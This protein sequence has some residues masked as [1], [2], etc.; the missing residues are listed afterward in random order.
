MFITLGLSL[1]FLMGMM[2]CVAFLTYLERKIIARFQLRLGP[3]VVGPLG[4][5]Q[6]FADA[7]KMIHKETIIPDQC[8]R[9][10]FLFS[11]ILVFFLTMAP[12]A[13]LPLGETFYLAASEFDILYVMACAGLGAYGTLMAGWSSGSNYAFLGG[14]RAASQVIAY[15]ISATLALL[16]IMMTAQSYS[17]HQVVQAQATWWFILPHAPLAVTFFIALLAESHRTPFD[18]PEAESDL[19]AGYKVEYS[20]MGF[21]L[22]MLSEYAH[23]IFASALFSLCFLGGWLPIHSALAW[24][25][26]PL[27][28][29][30]KICFILFLFIWIRST[31]PRYRYDQLMRIGWKVLLPFN[32]IWFMITAGVLRW[33]FV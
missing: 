27:W 15:E 5:L 31:F 24:I 29:A 16:C 8:H 1:L 32:L 3:E 28:M 12:W 33:M 7:F 9:P 17:F 2:V 13:V 10:W 30:G 14:L 26:G 11:P 4:L 6:P 25:P 23:I 19:V 18:L 22:L 20:S 21:G